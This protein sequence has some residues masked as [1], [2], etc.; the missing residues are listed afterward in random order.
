VNQPVYEP[1]LDPEIAEH[2][3][4]VLTSPTPVVGL[5]DLSGAAIAD[6]LARPTELLGSAS[7][8]VHFRNGI[9]C[10][11]VAEALPFAEEY[12]ISEGLIKKNI[13]VWQLGYRVG[14]TAASGG[15]HDRGG[16]TDV[17]QYSDR[18]IECWRD[19]GWTMQHRTR[20][21]GFDM[22]HAHGWPWGCDHLSAAGNS[23]ATQWRHNTNGLLSRGRISGKWPIDP[24]RDALERLEEEMIK[25]E[26][27]VA[28]MINSPALLKKIADAV[29][30]A[31][32]SADVI[33]NEWADKDA[34]PS[35]KG[36]KPNPTIAPKTALRRLSAAAVK[37]A[38][39]SNVV[40]VN[41]TPAPPSQ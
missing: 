22:D 19:L 32:W 38:V 8:R 25:P 34:D 36:S 20:A 1:G 4:A 9:T 31:V 29:A 16:C 28:A 2:S 17:D 35:V 13:D 30:P 11:C 12:M 5:L 26:D 3:L 40:V 18:Q 37:A 23:Q 24:W 27:I 14:G 39:P 10:V 33:P 15:T 7:E 6:L 21:Q 41:P